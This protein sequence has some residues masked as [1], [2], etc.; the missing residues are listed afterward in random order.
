MEPA[1]ATR[2]DLPFPRFVVATY[3][4]QPVPRGPEE[5]AADRRASGRPARRGPV[6]VVDDDEDTRE[7]LCYLLCDAGY[8]VVSAGSGEQALELMRS[9]P[10]PPELAI[11][12]MI[13]PGMSGGDV[14]RELRQSPRLASV[15]VMVLSGGPRSEGAAARIGVEG[16]LDK[17]PSIGELLDLVASLTHHA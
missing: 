15:P 13:M 3:D 8:R 14:I 4:P 7:I 5:L 10:E 17:P 16:W 6:V 1:C 2:P 9:L 12:D 11:I